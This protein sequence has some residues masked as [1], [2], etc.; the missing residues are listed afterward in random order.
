MTAQATDPA[1][2]AAS[3]RVSQLSG[4]AVLGVLVGLLAGFGASLFIKVEHEI[5]HLLWTDLPEALGHPTAPSWLVVALLVVGALIVQLARAMPG[6]GGHSPLEGLSLSVGPREIASV[7]V[8]ALGTLCFGAALGPEAPLMAVGTALGA[9][10]FRDANNPVRL[11]MMLAG[12]MAAIGAIFGNPLVT[13]MLLLEVAVLAGPRMANSPVLLTA[14]TAV[15]AGY[16]LQVGIAGWSGLGSVSLA[17]PGLPAYPSVQVVD[18]LLAIPV[19]LL[20]AI[21]AMAARLG[22][23][24]I[25]GRAREH[26]LAVILVAAVLIALTAV[27]VVTITG[28]SLDLVLFSGQDAMPEY[29]AI[30]SLGTAAVVLVGRFVAYTL[31]LGSGFRGGPIFPAVALGAILAASASLAV[32]SASVSALA[33]TAIAAAVAAALRLPFTATLLAV[34]LTSSA[35]GATTVLAI[36]GTVVGMLARV[37]AEARLDTLAPPKF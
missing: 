23:E 18:L 28:G 12:S 20:V 11:V 29:L 27:A 6:G 4:L 35:G 10:A 36:V 37:A 1:A 25:E 8:A 3:P 21:V 32:D 24:R 19:A 33:A 16:T 15:A 2:A 7:L 30:T 34:L 5:T 31:S 9:L 26:P 13:A 14:L 17:V 22:A